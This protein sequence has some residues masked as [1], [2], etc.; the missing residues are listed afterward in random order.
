MHVLLLPS[1]FDT[2]D[3]PW[4]GTFFRDQ[5]NA[6]RR[7]GVRAGIAFVERRSLGRIRPGSLRKSHFQVTFEHGDVPIARMR[8]WSVMAQTV[9]GGLLWCS[10]MRR[11]VRRYVDVYGM[12]DLVHGHAGL[13]GGYAAS[14]VAGE[15]GVPYVVTE[16][17]S[18][19]LVGEH[20]PKRRQLLAETYQGAAAVIAVSR[21]LKRAVDHVMSDYRAIVVPNTVDVDYFTIP[22]EPRPNA[23]FRFLTVCDLVRSKRVDLAIRG[24]ATLRRRGIAASLTCVGTG[25]E[26]AHLAQLAAQL[27]VADDVTFTGALT[28]EGVRREMQRSGALILPS[29]FETFGVVLI[30]ALATGLPVIATRCGGPSEIVDASLGDLVDPDN[31]TQ[32]TAAMARMAE[33]TFEGA[34]DP[35]A[36]R[37]YV[38]R[39]F[40]YDAIGR[41]LVDVYR[42]VLDD[43]DFDR[44]ELAAG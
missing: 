20:A 9:P 5:A 16:H 21:A 42:R 1:W 4:R 32:L 8:G 39:R 27:G 22:R 14:Q 13:W 26:A 19:V 3:K 17:A 36:L 11:L 37:A 40:G 29:T 18:R 41:R 35:A 33:G 31:E 6:L 34:H 12:P 25:K 7:Q 43:R 44:W 15:L 38:A 10:L 2:V 30:E 23:P 24:L 28:R